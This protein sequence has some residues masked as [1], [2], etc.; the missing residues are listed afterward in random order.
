MLTASWYNLFVGLFSTPAV[1][2]TYL[3]TINWYALG[4]AVLTPLLMLLARHEIRLRRL[5]A[6]LDFMTSFKLI[7]LNETT[8]STDPLGGTLQVQPAAKRG[9][10]DENPS[11]EYVK[12]K[13]ISDLKVDAGS[14]DQR[15][16]NGAQ[17]DIER[18]SI[19]IDIATR[20][21]RNTNVRLY[22]SSLS[23]VLISFYGFTAFFAAFG[24]G[25]SVICEP[26]SGCGRSLSTTIGAF[27]FVG[28]FVAAVR[29]L[30]RSL[31]VFDLSAFTFL[32]HAGEMVASVLLVV[33]LFNAFPDLMWNNSTPA[34]D[35][36]A[37]KADAGVGP[38][39]VTTATSTTVVPPTPA[40]CPP[41]LHKT[42]CPND[43]SGKSISWI[44]LALAPLLGLL[45]QSSSKFLLVKMQAFVPWTKTTDDRFVEVTK[46]ISLDIIDGIDFETRFRLEECGIYDVQN[47]ATYNPIMLFIE[48]PFGIYQCIDW[49]AQAQ[50]CHILG[51]DKFLIFREL[52]IRTIFDLER[53]IDSKDSPDVYDRICAAILLAPTRGLRRSAALAAFKFAIVKEGHTELEDVDAYFLWLNDEIAKGDEGTKAIEHLMAWIGDDL[54]VRRLRR[55][56]NDIARSLE[57]GSEFLKDSKRNPKNVNT[58]QSG[59]PAEDTAQ[60]ENPV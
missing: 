23:F 19:Y 60:G 42:P 31:S 50:L 22:L 53:A 48:T 37:I 52:N 32:R 44:W 30:L 51:P 57:P 15:L 18:I 41:A 10:S 3:A 59:S 29:M 24:Y 28:A 17:T 38:T 1:I 36:T 16:L 35:V 26:T 5:R 54:H 21:F 2:F 12:S 39:T 56:W 6:I 40:T 55:L 58:E 46:I 34:I 11:F 13:Y 8:A 4:I 9:R 47:L 45:P 27:A 20:P 43:P 14:E 33:L 7:G 49:V 25:N